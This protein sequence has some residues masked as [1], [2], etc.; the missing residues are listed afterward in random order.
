M[1]LNMVLALV[2][3]EECDST[4]VPRTPGAETEGDTQEV[5]K[6]TVTSSYS[7]E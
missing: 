2:K 3:E 6:V 1:W 5:P 7:T 4:L